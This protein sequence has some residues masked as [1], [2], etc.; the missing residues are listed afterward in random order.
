MLCIPVIFIIIYFM[1]L[2]QLM[3]SLL[4]HV[5][6]QP[7]RFS[8]QPFSSMLSASINDKPFRSPSQPLFSF[9]LKLRFLYYSFCLLQS[10]LL[11]H[12]APV[13]PLLIFNSCT[14]VVLVFQFLCHSS[15]T[16][17]HRFSSFLSHF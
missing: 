15:Y 2:M 1:F 13:H 8:S 7:F 3:L 11:P 16:L 14:L 12:L 17:L 10:F 4:L 9:M 6:L 5:K